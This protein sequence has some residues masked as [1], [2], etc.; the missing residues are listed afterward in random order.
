VF[1]CGDGQRM[2][3]AVRATLPRI[4]GDDGEAWLAELERQGR[5]VADVFA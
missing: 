4:H 5:Y 1:V 3:P 2:A